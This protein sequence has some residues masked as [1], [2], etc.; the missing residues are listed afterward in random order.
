MVLFRQLVV[1]RLNLRIRG[2]RRQPQDAV[3]VDFTGQFEV[4]AEES[5][6]RGH[7]PPLQSYIHF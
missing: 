4:G 5:A 3:I 6:A 1:L 2:M 7:G